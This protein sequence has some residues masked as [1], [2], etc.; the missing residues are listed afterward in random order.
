MSTLVKNLIPLIRDRLIAPQPDFWGDDELIKILGAGCK[1]LWR[2][3]VD[4]KQEHYL[5]IDNTNVSLA[6]N[7]TTLTGV[8][9]DVHKIY[10]I[11]PR[12]LSA[13][14]TNHGLVFQPLDY[15]DQRF[16]LM[17][18]REAIDPANTI[19]YYA[20][21]G[22]G[23]PSGATTILV[24]PK[25]TGTVLISFCYVPTLTPLTAES[26]IPIPGEADN[27]L[28]SYTVAFARSKEREDRSPDPAW[29]S[30]YN[31]EKQHLLES[32]GLRQ[33]QEPQYVQA[34]YDEY[35]A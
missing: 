35:W 32:L 14:G 12:D 17:R 3:I 13:N 33:Y 4:L 18:S 29:L 7:A 23:S 30:I 28:I 8:P 27:A 5:T 6:A 25:L 10:M 20:I 11:E 31:T 9:A 19:I 16:Q 22:S 26:V 21:H 1:D 34:L 2:D 24:A 15:N